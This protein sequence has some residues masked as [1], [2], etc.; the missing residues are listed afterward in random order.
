VSFMEDT[1]AWHGKAP[2][3]EEAERALEEIARHG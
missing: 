2:T 1:A 3:A